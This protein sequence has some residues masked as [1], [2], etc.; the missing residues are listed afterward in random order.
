MALR[1]PWLAIG[2]LLTSCASTV[3]TPTPTVTIRSPGG[4]VRA[5]YR[6][7]LAQ[8]AA[9]WQRGLMGRTSL[10]DGTGMLFVFP[11]DQ[12]R[13]FWMKDTLIELD[14]LFVSA[15]GRINTV[16][17]SVRPCEADPCPVR[18]SAAPSRYVLEL[19]GGEAARAHVA[20][21]D[22]LDLS[23]AGTGGTAAPR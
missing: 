4:Q 6:V 8:D 1:S 20:V 17:A 5:S 22:A 23:G 11:D 2:L 18:S 12:H 21:G 13:S 19:A 14:M 3:P 10:E 9:A 7:E 16:A 15:D